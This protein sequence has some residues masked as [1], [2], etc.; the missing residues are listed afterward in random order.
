M[1]DLVIG[2]IIGA[3]AGVM[4]AIGFSMLRTRQLGRRHAVDLADRE[5][6]ILELRQEAAEDKE[7]N[8]RLRHELAVKTPGHL[9]ETA[10]A[11]EIQRDGALSERDQALEQLDL[12]QR[13]LAAARTRLT[14]QDAK[15]GRYRE[16]LQE[17]RLSLEAQGRDRGL[18]SASSML[19]TGDL[20]VADGSVDHADHG[21]NDG[22]ADAVVENGAIDHGGAVDHGEAVD[23]GDP[24][25]HVR[26][27]DGDRAASEAEIAGAVT[28]DATPEPVD[29]SAGD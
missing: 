23:H 8:R 24:V 1:S 7:T 29:L 10:T 27:S 21:D 15:L 26:R 28:A 13:D 20:P 5:D 9:L 19:D 22:P 3:T 12:V 17:I 16:A 25:D 18:E 4:L 6:T 2:L 11:A 14:A